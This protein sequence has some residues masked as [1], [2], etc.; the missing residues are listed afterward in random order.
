MKSLCDE[1]RLRREIRT[2]FISSAKQ[3]SSERGEDFIRF[4]RASQKRDGGADGGAVLRRH[5]AGD[6]PRLT[7]KRQAHSVAGGH[8]V[9]R[10]AYCRPLSGCNF[11]AVRVY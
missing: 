4:M 5:R 11:S 9:D 8:G 6:P 1:I 10:R 3:I 2:D 7:G